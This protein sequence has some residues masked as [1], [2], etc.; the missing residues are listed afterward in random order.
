MKAPTTI[1]YVHPSIRAHYVEKSKRTGTSIREL[2]NADVTDFLNTYKAE[3]FL[4]DPD[5]T[6]LGY[7]LTPENQAKMDALVAATGISQYRVVQLALE[8]VHGVPPV[9]SEPLPQEVEA[10]PQIFDTPPQI[11]DEPEVVTKP[12]TDAPA[13]A[14]LQNAYYYPTEP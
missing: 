1:Q 8:Q 3:H 4:G 13:D 5:T 14:T 12:L 6:Y 2:V 7:A 11:S 10:P 9:F